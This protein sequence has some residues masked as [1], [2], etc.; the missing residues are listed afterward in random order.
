MNFK[1]PKGVTAAGVLLALVPVLLDANVQAALGSLLG[2]H[3]GTKVAAAGAV[4]A[5]L[6]RSLF[7]ASGPTEPQG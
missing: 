3:A 1:L 4:L 7:G 2:E 5:A 6:G